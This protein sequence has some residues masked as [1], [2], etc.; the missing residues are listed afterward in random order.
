MFDMSDRKSPKERSNVRVFVLKPIEGQKT[1]SSTGLVDPGLFEGTNEISAIM[2]TR[3]L[4]WSLKYKNGGLP[5]ALKQSFT[6]FSKLFAFVQQYFERRG[7]RIV[8]V[9]D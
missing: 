2:D 6:S 1:T 7:I 8:E 4:L 3:S 5:G 9:I